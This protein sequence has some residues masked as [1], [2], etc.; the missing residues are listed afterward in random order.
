MNM[1]KD[2]QDIKAMLKHTLLNKWVEWATMN[3]ID[4]IACTPVISD[5]GTKF[6]VQMPEALI[7][8]EGEEE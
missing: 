1:N 7:P 5:F 4:W 2:I 8:V 3:N 6:E